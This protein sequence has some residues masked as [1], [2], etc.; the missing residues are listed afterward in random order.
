MYKMP[1]P[2]LP[3]QSK[4]PMSIDQF[5]TEIADV[6]FAWFGNSI[7]TPDRRLCPICALAAKKHPTIDNNAQWQRA[8]NYLGLSDYDAAV[9]ITAADR[10]INLN[11]AVDANVKMVRQRFTKMMV[12]QP[13]PRP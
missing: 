13:Q 2:P 10:A 6:E 7:R 11:L 5:L 8:A 4:S 12:G 3:N 9:I 1:N